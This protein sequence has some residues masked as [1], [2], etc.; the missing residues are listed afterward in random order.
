MKEPSIYD[1]YAYQLLHY[2]VTQQGYQIVTIKQQREDIWLMN[3][4]HQTYPIIRLSTTDNTK[5][6]RNIDYLRQVHRAIADMVKREGKLCILNTNSEATPIN[7]DFLEQIVIQPKQCENT[8]LQEAFPGI[9]EIPHDVDDLQ[10][11][12]VQITRSLEEVQMN[13]LRK[14]RKETGFFKRIPRLTGI[15]CLICI[16]MW[17]IASLVAV[18][19]ESNIQAAILCG[20]YYKMNVVSMHEVW[21]FLTAGFLHIDIFHLLMNLMV[22]I[23]IGQA[24]EKSFTKWQY[25]IILLVAIF[26]GN[27]FVYLTEGNVI[28]LGISGGIF[29]LLGA[30]IATLFENGSIRHPMIKGTVLRLVVLNILISLMPG[31]SLFAH[32]GGF[33]SGVFMGVIFVKSKRWANLKIHVTISFAI[34]IGLSCAMA[35]RINAVDPMDKEVDRTLLQNVRGFGWDSYADYMQSSY[36]NYYT[37]EDLGL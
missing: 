3:P 24:C 2:F 35:T 16:A 19:L 4:H 5:T 37:K 31:I 18:S 1:I 9:T 23:N 11:E 13:M 17:L 28:G 26:T 30:F 36:L 29:G 25:L 20:A 6:L 12:Y 8:A 22:L 10:K 27:L 33:I 34:L 32:L 7:N 21:R 15:I 14:Q